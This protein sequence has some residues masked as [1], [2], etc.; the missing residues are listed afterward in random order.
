MNTVES[1]EIEPCKFCQ[2]DNG[3]YLFSC[4][5]CCARYITSIPLKTLR[6]GWMARFKTRTS[7]AFYSQLESEVSERWKIKQAAHVR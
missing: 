5:G 4:V 7:D 3:N 6:S 1:C 2:I